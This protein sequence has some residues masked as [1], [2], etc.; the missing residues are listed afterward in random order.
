MHDEPADTGTTAPAA[1]APDERNFAAHGSAA[2][3]RTCFPR[4][5][6]LR[7]AGADADLAGWRALVGARGLA[8]LSRWSATRLEHEGQLPRAV[9]RRFA[10]AF[11]LGRAVERA[12]APVRPVIR[13]ARGVRDVVLADVRGTEREQFFAL[14]LDG[15][16]RLQRRVVVGVGTLTCSLVHPRE[17]FQA[18]V[19]EGAA[20]VVVAHNHPSG[21]PAPSGED[22]EVTRRLVEAGQLL[23]IPLV[24]HVVVAAEAC[25]SLREL[26]PELG[27]VRATRA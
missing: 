14:L 10:A 24:D 12:R 4:D 8:A 1:A 17:V 9:A 15:R 25:V 26:H 23:G 21:D 18:A 20:A 22:L 6:S 19:R 27:F 13:D 5:P 7:L 11:A 2:R 16:H 3:F